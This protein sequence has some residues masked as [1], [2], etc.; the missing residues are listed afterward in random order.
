MRD[1]A[2][3]RPATLTFILFMLATRQ[4]VPIPPLTHG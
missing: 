1:V 3:A 4:V 2:A